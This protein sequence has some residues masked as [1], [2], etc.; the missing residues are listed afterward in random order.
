MPLLPIPLPLGK[1]G[2]PLH[3]S[4]LLSKIWQS[5]CLSVPLLNRV[6]TVRDTRQFR[7]K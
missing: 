6:A 3:H 2:P 1:D 7:A 5:F 4:W